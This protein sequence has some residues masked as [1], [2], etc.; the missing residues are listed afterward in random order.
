[1]TVHID[2][3]QIVHAKSTFNKS[4]IK[5]QHKILYV[6][7]TSQN[8]YTLGRKKSEFEGM[9]QIFSFIFTIRYGVFAKHGVK[10]AANSALTSASKQVSSRFCRGFQVPLHI[11]HTST[12]GALT[13]RQ[14]PHLGFGCKPGGFFRTVFLD[15]LLWSIASWYC[16]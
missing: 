6:N 8:Q 13:Y 3:L 2:Q 16:V 10:S 14:W 7:E 1:M 4:T 11:V 15:L 12:Q 5:V 9:L